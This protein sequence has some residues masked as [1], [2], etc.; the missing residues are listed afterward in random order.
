LEN[1][2]GLDFNVL[3]Q[4][5]QLWTTPLDTFDVSADILKV[6]HLFFNTYFFAFVW[7]YDWVMPTG[8]AY[9]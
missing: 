9:A 3:L 2:L 6:L 4:P 1:S 8:K 7:G 5:F